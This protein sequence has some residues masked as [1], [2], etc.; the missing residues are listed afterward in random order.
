MFLFIILV[1]YVQNVV[2]SLRKKFIVEDELLDEVFS[3]LDIEAIEKRIIVSPD[4][5]F[6]FYFFLLSFFFFWVQQRNVVLDMALINETIAT[7]CKDVEVTRLING[8]F[9]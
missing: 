1:I 9:I 3:E 8:L 5:E 4:S 2:K 7:V 6:R